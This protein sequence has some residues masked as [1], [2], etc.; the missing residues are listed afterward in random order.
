MFLG[1]H[2]EFDVHDWIDA[3]SLDDDAYSL[4][5][6]RSA[7]LAWSDATWSEPDPRVWT[8]LE[9]GQDWFG[10]TSD[11]LCWWQLG[12]PARA[13]APLPMQ[14]VLACANDCLDRVGTARV[15]SADL[16]LPLLPVPSQL[17]QVVATS[18]W[19]DLDRRASRSFEVA[20]DAGAGQQPV[21]PVAL[22]TALRRPHTAPF[23]FD[24]VVEPAAPSDHDPPAG[25]LWFTPSP[26][27][28]SIV[29]GCRGWGL[30]A[31]GWI[32]AFVGETLRDLGHAGMVRV[33]VR[34]A[35]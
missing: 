14:A 13:G 29:G 2:G 32:G 24:E 20:A 7:A 18:S 23:T 9:A 34:D 4:F 3:A 5:T 19:F 10:R 30:E 6:R 15:T 26:V 28:T 27:R 8:V 22:L 11:R 16:L 21:D 35:H 12:L 33:E 31:A 25:D 1:I 17:G